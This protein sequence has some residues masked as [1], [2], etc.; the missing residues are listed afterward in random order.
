V[1]AFAKGSGLASE[2]RDRQ[3]KSRFAID[4]TPPSLGCGAAGAQHL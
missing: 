1:T 2:W 4:A 3:N